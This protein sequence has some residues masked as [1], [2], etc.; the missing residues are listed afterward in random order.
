MTNI[1]NPNLPA[2]PEK[3]KSR[4]ALIAIIVAAVVALPLLAF[5]IFGVLLA[6]EQNANNAAD[7]AKVNF[8][9]HG[10]Y[11]K[12]GEVDAHLQ[13]R[14]DE[15]EDVVNL[16]DA[17]YKV[18][19]Y[20]NMTRV[21][22]LSVDYNYDGL[23]KKDAVAE[24]DTTRMVYLPENIETKDLQ[25]TLE[26]IFSSQGYDISKLVYKDGNVS[27]TLDRDKP[28]GASEAN[29]SKEQINVS[30]APAN[31]YRGYIQI[32]FLDYTEST[33][34]LSGIPVWSGMTPIDEY[35]AKWAW[36]KDSMESQ[37]YIDKMCALDTYS[38]YGYW[39]SRFECL[40]DAKILANN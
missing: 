23:P 17:K 28:M 9:I 5:L 22:P 24:V 15:S 29:P 1:T 37:T 6:N 4:A 14:I 20:N 36:T 27:Y 35:D 32:S 30:V 10:G 18:K 19:G 3:K 38:P 25:V 8:I 12:A 39:D 26:K 13:R 33:Y 21:K 16:L 31:Q 7:E 2:A 11:A 34:P 40:Q